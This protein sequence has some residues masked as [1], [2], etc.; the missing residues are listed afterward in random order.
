MIVIIPQLKLIFDDAGVPAD[1]NQN[2]NKNK[3]CLK[4]YGIYIL[5]GFIAL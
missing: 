4:N 1:S 3:F 5:A 2:N